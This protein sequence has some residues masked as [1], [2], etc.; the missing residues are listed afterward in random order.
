M[1]DQPVRD[2][3]ELV[4]EIETVLGIGAAPLNWPIGVGADFH[5]VFDLRKRTV[6][7]YA[8]EG[9]G[10]RP[11]PVEVGDHHDARLTAI[12]GERVVR[13]FR[14]SLQIVAS[15]GSTF[16]MEEDLASPLTGVFFGSALRHFGLQPCLDDPAKLAPAPRAH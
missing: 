11:A 10:E 13:E 3:L 9:K 6:L 2:P 16:A 1:L 12:A 15:A 5:G 4:D 8:R 7:L 14:E